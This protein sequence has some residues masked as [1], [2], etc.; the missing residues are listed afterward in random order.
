M[1]RPAAPPAPLST[2]A[3]P[4]SWTVLRVE[5][6]HFAFEVRRHQSKYFLVAVA[7]AVDNTYASPRRHVLHDNV[8]QEDALAGAHR[9]K[10][11]RAPS[12]ILWGRSNSRGPERK[13]RLWPIAFPV[14][15]PGVYSGLGR[16]GGTICGRQ[17][18]IG[19]A[20]RNPLAPGLLLGR[21]LSKAG[22]GY[23]PVLPHREWGEPSS[24]WC[25]K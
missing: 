25:G 19:S 12:Q 17:V 18:Y 20:Q 5:R 6:Q 8:V 14:V 21:D 9:P 2:T 3:P 16:P 11:V 4:S 24:P 22:G 15:R 13:H 7:F 23:L 1:D 10:H